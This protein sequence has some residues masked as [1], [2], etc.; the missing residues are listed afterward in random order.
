MHT[1]FLLF[2]LSLNS[3]LLSKLLS[4]GKEGQFPDLE[5]QLAF[6][7]NSFDRAKALKSGVIIPNRG[8]N[9]EYDSAE[10]VV[11]T[12]LKELDQYLK[13]QRQ[14]LKCQVSILAKLA[15]IL[16]Y[17]ALL[18]Q[19][20]TYW[21]TGRNRFQLEVPIAALS[22]LKIQDYELSSQKKGFRR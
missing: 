8:V 21:G 14:R 2:Y 18:L 20:V 3:S 9:V 13:E 16:H 15:L 4:T 7:E 1:D 12:V 22:G 17:Y 10:G 5:E 19:S 6:Y 11:T